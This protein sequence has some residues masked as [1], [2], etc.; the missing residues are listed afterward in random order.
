MTT[1]EILD[2][3]QVR[4]WISEEEAVPTFQVLTDWAPLRRLEFELKP[5]EER[6]EYYDLVQGA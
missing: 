2:E 5:D 1:A 4:N 6:I 3:L